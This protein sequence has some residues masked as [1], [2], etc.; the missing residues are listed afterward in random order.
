MSTALTKPV[1]FPLVF[2]TLSPLLTPSHSP[3]TTPCQIEM[4][5][6]TREMQATDAHTNA[7][8]TRKDYLAKSVVELEDLVGRLSGQVGGRGMV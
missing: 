2:I 4:D 8:A 1:V 6:K 7:L 3:P 5:I